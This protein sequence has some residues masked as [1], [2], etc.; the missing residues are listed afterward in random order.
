MISIGQNLQS[1]LI[2]FFIAEYQINILT[3]FWLL[4]FRQHLK[5]R[6]VNFMRVFFHKLKRLKIS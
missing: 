3:S 6:K 4:F 1:L 2:P 5:R